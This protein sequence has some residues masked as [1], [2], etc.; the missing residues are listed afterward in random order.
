MKISCYTISHNP[1]IKMFQE[2]IDSVNKCGFDE[3]I[4][5]D[6][7]SDKPFDADYRFEKWGGNDNIGNV[8]NKGVE[9][10]SGDYVATI[11]DDDYFI[12]ENVAKLKKFIEENPDADVYHFPCELT[13]EFTGLWGVEPNFNRLL[14]YNQIPCGSWVKR[15]VLLKEKY[16]PEQPEDWE[17]WIRL[18]K[19]GYRFAYFPE[20]IYV[21]RMRK[22]SISAAK[23]DMMKNFN[24]R[25]LK[26]KQKYENYHA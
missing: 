2:A 3:Y 13:G 9:L 17:L 22:D 14:E 5:V 25:K 18:Y 24:E 20:P 11:D 1:D 10:C 12:P 4:L 23:S 7:C 8:R 6:D 21:H 26:L 16:E 15:S 19:N